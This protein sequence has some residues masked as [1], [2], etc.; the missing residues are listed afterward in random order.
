VIAADPHVAILAA[1]T[2]DEL[3]GKLDAGALV[4]GFAN[5]FLYVPVYR[6]RVDPFLTRMPLDLHRELATRFALALAA[7]RSSGEQSLSFEPAALD[8]WVELYRQLSVLRFGPAGSACQRADTLTL[9]LLIVY[10]LLDRTTTVRVE[11]VDAAAAAWRYC[12]AGAKLIYGEEL[13][14]ADSGAAKLV[15]YLERLP[16][17]KRASTATLD[18]EVFNGHGYQSDRLKK[19]LA[20]ALDAGVI[21]EQ[22]EQSTSGGRPATT[23]ASC[24]PLSTQRGQS[25]ESGQSR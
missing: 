9:R 13:A 16:A 5:R 18:R 12:D 11:H 22:H 14:V 23:Y 1:I 6:S 3:R 19:A 2:P 17:G 15:A 10:A 25:G 21:D 20:L 4:N 24:V 8:R 7:A